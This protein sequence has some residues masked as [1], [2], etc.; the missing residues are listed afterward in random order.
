MMDDD[1]WWMVDG[2]MDD[3]WMDGWMC[4]DMDGC[5]WMDGWMD[6]WMDAWMKTQSGEPLSH[7]KPWNTKIK[8]ALL[9][10]GRTYSRD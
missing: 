5:A 1:G 8:S 6:G 9:I 3:G 10:G 2:W 4:M 7:C